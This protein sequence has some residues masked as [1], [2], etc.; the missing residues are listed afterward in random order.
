MYLVYKFKYYIG[1]EVDLVPIGV[2]H[3]KKTAKKLAKKKEAMYKEV[4]TI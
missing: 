1:D 4:N 2:T 3:D